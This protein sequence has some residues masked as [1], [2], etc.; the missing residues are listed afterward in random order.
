MMVAVVSLTGSDESLRVLIEKA[1]KLG[2]ASALRVLSG[3]LA[4]DA[5][6]LVEKS[7]ATSTSPDGEAWKP[8]KTR[9][10]QPLVKS[11]RLS[12]S[13]KTRVSS[14]G[15]TLYTNTSYAAV[16]QFGAQT[17]ARFQARTKTGRFKSKKSAA[18]AKGRVVNVVRVSGATIPARPFFPG[19]SLPP[20]WRSRF[21]AT[22][23]EF[24]REFFSG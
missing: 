12:R 8:L 10:G 19:A 23:R 21:A 2:G 5:R 7:F 4:V 6:K 18:K 13:V 24:Y 16:H 3:R 11:G 20:E 14:K 17:K 15:F 1:K 9:K 22:T